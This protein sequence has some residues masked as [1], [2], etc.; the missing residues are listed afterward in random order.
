MY[1]YLN[2]AFILVIHFKSFKN[3]ASQK[4]TSAISW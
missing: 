2:I 3:S 1:V 4:E